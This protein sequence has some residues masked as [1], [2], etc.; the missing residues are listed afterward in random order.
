MSQFLGKITSHSN[1]C[2]Y[3]DFSLKRKIMDFMSKIPLILDGIV[4]PGFA[5]FII[6]GVFFLIAAYLCRA[7]KSMILKGAI[8]AVAL[9]CASFLSLIAN[10][11][12]FNMSTDGWIAIM[13]RY[14]SDF[15]YIS[16]TKGD[17]LIINGRRFRCIENKQENI[18]FSVVNDELHAKVNL[19]VSMVDPSKPI[20][21]RHTLKSEL[22]SIVRLEL[23]KRSDKNSIEEKIISKYKNTSIAITINEITIDRD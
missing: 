18:V 20:F 23:R 4:S 11:S 9:S 17:Y 12:A 19:D 21:N 15:E 7:L 22:I 5:T 13:D 16:V 2:S 8:V 6:F 1:N 3:N 10:F 14:E